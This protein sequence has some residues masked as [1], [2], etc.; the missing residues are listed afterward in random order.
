MISFDPTEEQELIRDSVREFA[1]SEMREIAR[2]CD[3]AESL[4]DEFLEQSWELG[5][6]NAQIPE[7][8]GGPGLERSPITSVLVAEELG[9]GCPGLATAALAPASLI[10]PLLDLGTEEQRQAHLPRFAGSAYRAGALALHEQNWSFELANL[11]T[12][13][14]PKNGEFRITGT[15]RMVPMGE[16]AELFLVVA[17]CGAREGVAGLQAFLVPADTPGVSVERE[18]TMG[19]RAVPFARVEFDGARVGAEAQLG[20]EAGCDVARLANLARTASL[21]LALGQSRAVLDFAIDYAKERV[22]FGQPIGQKQ[23]IAFMLAEMRIE[24]NSM[25]W[26]VWQAASQL[27]RG[28]DANRETRL[29]QTYTNREAMRLADNGVQIFGGHG[30]IR[31]YPIEMWFRNARVLTVLEGATAL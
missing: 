10:Y 2:A 21:A 1:A 29:A 18:H 22:A 4:P 6:A 19:L 13:A 14:E 23:A 20:G 16:R 28:N 3:E 31:D 12:L 25:R 17:R 27:E 7:A 24:L 30:F 8:Y 5:L 9:Y 26:L 15:K 11:G